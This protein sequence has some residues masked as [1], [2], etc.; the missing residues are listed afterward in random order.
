MSDPLGLESGIV[1]LAEYDDRWP[2]LFAAE[3]GRLLAFSDGI[4]LRIE[5]IGS[6]SIAGMCAKPVL[7]IL[8]GRPSGTPVDP[9]LVCIQR[10]GY[11][12]RGERGIAGREFFR[13]GEPRAYHVHLVE[14]DGA[15]WR[16]YLDFRNY[17]RAHAEAAARYADLKRSL[18]ARF[19]RDREAYIDGK[20]A[21]VRETVATAAIWTHI[22]L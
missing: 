19:P 11:V 21:F 13:R 10:A 16:E 20:T 7:D 5:H 12:H 8:A 17:L 3:A 6:T 15:L 4:A 9:Y 1:R 14:Q 22:D 18:A 2:V